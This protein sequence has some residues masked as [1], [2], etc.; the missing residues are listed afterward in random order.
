MY[1]FWQKTQHCIIAVKLSATEAEIMYTEGK[2]QYPYIKHHKSQPKVS[3]FY[4]PDFHSV[5][6]VLLCSITVIC[7]NIEVVLPHTP[8]EGNP[9]LLET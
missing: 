2:A 9:T 4:F 7:F 3:T 8:I 1:H 6:Q 5:I